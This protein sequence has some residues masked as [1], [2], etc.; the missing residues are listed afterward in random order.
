MDPATVYGMA[1]IAGAL[2]AG[3]VGYRARNGDES[4]SWGKFAQDAA[5]GVVLSL[6][7][8]ASGMNA[9]TTDSNLIAAL[10]AGLASGYGIN[11]ARVDADL[12][13]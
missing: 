5:T 12:K 10:I 2:L 4:F 13:V 7:V 11:S 8:V 6:V 1:G 3:Y 9:M